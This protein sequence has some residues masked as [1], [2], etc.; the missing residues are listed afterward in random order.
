MSSRGGLFS[1]AAGL[2]LSCSLPALGQDFPEGAG[3]Q[4]VTAVCGGCHDINRLKIGY[5]PEGWRTVVR[6]MQNVE[7]PVPADQWDTVTEYLIKSF[8]E[9][10]RPAAVVLSGPVEAA[11]REW[12][13]LTPGSRPHDPLAT[14]DGAFW[15]T[16]Q[17]ANKL[18]RL[19]PTTGAMKEYPLKTFRTGP[20]GLTEDRDGNI[21]LP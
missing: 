10:P 14:R 11:I 8:P 15:W 18:G 2:L 12:P 4:M 21:W 3:K 5:T 17:L 6:M 20:H 16:G 19:D 7:T 9:R 1:V 13:V